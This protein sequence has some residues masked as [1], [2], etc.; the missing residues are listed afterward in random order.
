MIILFS[1]IE[2][3]E[4]DWILNLKGLEVFNVISNKTIKS[5]LV[6]QS[7]SPVPG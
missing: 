5:V 3:G 7:L 4:S 1:Q 6:F 2:E